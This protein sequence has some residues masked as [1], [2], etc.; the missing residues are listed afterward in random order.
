MG[1]YLGGCIVGDPAKLPW[2][3]LV[4]GYEFTRHPLPIYLLLAD[5]IVLFLVFKAYNYLKDERKDLSDARNGLT[6]LFYLSSFFILRGISEFYKDKPIYFRGV[7]FV[8]IFISILGLLGL[9]IFYKKIGRNFKADF[10]SIFSKIYV[11]IN[12]IK[13]K[14][15]TIFLLN[16]SLTIE[17]K[18][19]LDGRPNS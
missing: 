7:P 1:C 4:P 3:V 6:A 9:L 17:K 11:K 13:K 8:G 12:S 18:E 5:I 15:N 2:A 14:E 16:D 10:K 19:N